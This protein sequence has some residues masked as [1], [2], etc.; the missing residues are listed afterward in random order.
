[1]SDTL[2]LSM[3]VVHSPW[4]CALAQHNGGLHGI[5]SNPPYIPQ[6]VLSTL[7]VGSCCR[8]LPSEA[9]HDTIAPPP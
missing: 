9:H 8:A 4:D 7:Q 3:Q 2:V 5:L 6:A 1:M